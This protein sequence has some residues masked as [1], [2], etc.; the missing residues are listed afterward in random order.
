MS[1]YEERPQEEEADVEGHMRGLRED[2]AAEEDES[3]DVE[4]HMKNKAH[5]SKNKMRG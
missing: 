4:G 1:E 5:L 2:E 3:P